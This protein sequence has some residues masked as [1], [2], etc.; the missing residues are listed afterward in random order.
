M[1]NSW[2]HLILGISYY[3]SNYD[4]CGIDRQKSTYH[5]NFVQSLPIFVLTDL[6]NK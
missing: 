1:P 2:A 5:V 4:C 6:S 3:E